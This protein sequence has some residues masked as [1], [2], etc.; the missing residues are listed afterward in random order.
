MPKIV[1][2]V[3]V[4]LLLTSIVF[5]LKLLGNQKEPEKL[6]HVES[7]VDG[8]T[9]RLSGGQRV[10]LHGIDAP[11]TPRCMAG[12]AKAELEKQILGKSVYIKDKFTDYF[13]RD[14]GNIFVGDVYINSIIVEKGFARPDYEPSPYKQNIVD[15]YAKARTAKLGINSGACIKFKAPDPK[16]AIKGNVKRESHD[17]FYYPPSCAAYTSVRVDTSNLDQW[18]CTESEAKKVGFMKAPTCR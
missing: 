16:C 4:I 8:D 18:F 2:P 14:I 12:E 11:E 1:V 7:V 3:L 10:R 15:A 6:Y 9:F 17:H 5:N 13:G